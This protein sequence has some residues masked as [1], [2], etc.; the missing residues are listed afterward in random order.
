MKVLMLAGG[1]GNRLNELSSEDNKCMILVHN[2]PI[3]EHNLE[4]VAS[5]DIEEIVIVV[6][7][8][9]ETIVNHLGINFRGRNIRYVIQSDPK[10]LVHAIE[11]AQKTIK[12]DDFMLMLADEMLLRPRH[13][14]MIREFVSD[15]RIFGVCGIVRAADRNQVKRTYAIIQDEGGEIHRLIEK[16]RKTLNDYQGTGQC[17]FRNRIYDYIKFTPVHYERNEKELPDLIQCAIDDGMMVKSFLICEKYA[18]V[19]TWE[20]LAVAETFYAGA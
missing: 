17:V 5:L 12:G 4:F 10:G 2:K 16:P 19:N 20:D 11:C 1:R 9:A 18:N 13:R 7:Y 3:I 14:E 8:R 6:G 15:S